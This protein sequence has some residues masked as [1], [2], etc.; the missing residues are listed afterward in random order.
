M[1]I[2]M[3]N[4]THED[5]CCCDCGE[6]QKQVLNMYDICIGGTVFT[7]CDRCVEQLQSKTLK[8]IVERNGRVKSGRDMAIIRRRGQDD[9]ETRRWERYAEGRQTNAKE[10]VTKKGK[11][12]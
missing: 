7:I 10:P 12:K 6:T 9:Y 3:R 4:N 8:A 1:A 5:A 2:K 11:T